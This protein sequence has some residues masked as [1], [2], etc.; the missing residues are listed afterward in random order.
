M[1][2]SW[3]FQIVDSCNLKREVA[4]K[5]IGY[6]D[7]FLS[8]SRCQFA[9]A[10]LRDEYD[11]QLCFIACLFIAI[12]TCAGVTV[13]LDFVSKIVCQGLYNTKELSDMEM[14]VL[15]GLG[16][17]L[18]GPTPT[19]F[20][21]VFMQMMPPQEKPKVDAIARGAEALVEAAVMDYSLALQQPSLIA[22]L[23]ILAASDFLDVSYSN[24]LD[25]TKWMQS[26]ASITGLKEDNLRI[27]DFKLKLV[28]NSH[29]FRS[30]SCEV[31][32]T[33]VDERFC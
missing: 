3:A 25:K 8:N 33:G 26:V 32:T 24:P 11:F 30:D 12:K 9:E 15:R 17:R 14:N 16:W 29:L 7:R 10:A 21:H 4:I 19:E 20:V 6:F 28:R 2:V 23:C 1:M 31:S 5:A 18:N 22:V 27:Q 13:E